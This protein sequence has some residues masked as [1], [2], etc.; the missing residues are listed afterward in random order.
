MKKYIGLSLLVLW[1]LVTL[2]EVTSADVRLPAIVGD[3]MILQQQTGA[4]VW[5]WA[6]PGETVTVE[7]NWGEKATATTADNGKWKVFLKTPSHGGPHKIKINGKN[8]IIINNVIIGEVWLCAGQS[9]MGWR[10]SAVFEGA[11]DAASANYPNFRIFRSKRKHSHEPQEDC[12]AKWTPCTP[13]SAATCSAVSFYFAR[14]LHQELGIPIGIVLQP[15]AGTPIEGWMPREIQ[16][17]DP[18]TRKYAEEM[19]EFE[20]SVRSALPSANKNI[21]EEILKAREILSETYPL[22]SQLDSIARVCYEMNFEGNSSELKIVE[23]ARTLAAID[24]ERVPTNQHLLK[25]IKALRWRIKEQGEKENDEA[26]EREEV[27]ANG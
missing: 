26:R 1:G 15:Y 24:G 18:R 11:E 21:G 6:D 2:S 3:H 9:N 10:L 4:P 8:E 23:Y 14:K 12:I 5:G 16:M 17:N 20:M 22:D 27:M 19:D 13:D 7:G 25:G